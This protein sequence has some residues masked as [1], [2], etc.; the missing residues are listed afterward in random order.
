MNAQKIAIVGPI[1]ARVHDSMQVCLRSEISL[2]VIL[3]TPEY[4]YLLHN[5]TTTSG[6]Q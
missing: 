3:Y 4:I 5:L 1:R 2:E 6:L